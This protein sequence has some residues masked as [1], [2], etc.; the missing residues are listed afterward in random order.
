MGI[1]N[2]QV[3][4]FGVSNKLINNIVIPKSYAPCG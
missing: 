3:D 4:L 2:K 1:K